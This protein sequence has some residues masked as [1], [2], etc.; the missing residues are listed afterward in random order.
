[1][2]TA[3]FIVDKNVRVQNVNTAFTKLFQKAGEE[4]YDK[5]CGNAI[6]C[7]FPVKEETDCGKT[8]N[9]NKCQIRK[10]LVE[11]LTEKGG[12]LTALI[13]RE[14]VIA[15]EANVRNF[16]VTTTYFNFKGIDLVLVLVQDVSELEKQKR[17]LEELNKLKNELLGIAAHDLRNPITEIMT[18]SSLLL[19][20]PNELL[21]EHSSRLLKMI[22]S[23]SKFMRS[24]VNNLLD[25]SKIESGELKLRLKRLDYCTFLKEQITFNELLASEKNINLSFECQQDIPKIEF[26]QIQI[27]QVVNNLIGNAIKFSPKGSKIIVKIQPKNGN[28]ITKV[29]DQGPGIP[30]TE[31]PRLFK[32]FQKTS[33]EAPDGE[34]GTGLG[35][36]ISKKIIEKHGGT[37]GVESEVNRGSTFFFTLPI[38]R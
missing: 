8:V 3:I 18:A 37:I 34:E 35:L 16:Y 25:V 2:P 33:V 31:I 30:K 17:E 38:T 15:G 23:A 5:L 1:M 6:G 22:E 14:F 26:D 7:I 9:C 36:A 11:C 13:E 27:R 32:T 10:N 20:L 28:L 4:V 29:I 21:S 24:L 19:K 12:T